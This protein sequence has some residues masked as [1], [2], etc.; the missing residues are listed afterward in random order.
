MKTHQIT[1]VSPK[2]PDGS[3]ELFTVAPHPFKVSATWLAA[4]SSYPSVGDELDEDEAG[5][6]AL[7]PVSVADEEAAEENEKKEASPDVSA[8]GESTSG[9]GSKT[10]LSRKYSA[11]PV[12]VD[13]YVI[14]SVAKKKN[15]DGSL[16]V[17]IDNGENT[18]ATAEMMARMQ[19]VAGDYWVVQSDGYTY[20]N[21]KEVFERKYSKLED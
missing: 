14:V 20:L 9:D 17:A 4:Q 6:L 10:S 5:L 16:N 7:V 2:A 1:G 19:P 18:V 15:K 3:V 13:A 8:S 21:P 11:N 12:I